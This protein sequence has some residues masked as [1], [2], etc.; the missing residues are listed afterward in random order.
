[1]IADTSG[2]PCM[3]ITESE[4]GVYDTARVD[5]TVSCHGWIRLKTGEY[6]KLTDNQQF[7]EG[8]KNGR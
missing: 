3:I 2:T 6:F 1:M 4:L 5:V 8:V 7:I